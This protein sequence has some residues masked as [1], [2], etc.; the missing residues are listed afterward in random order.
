M[1]KTRRDKANEAILILQSILLTIEF[2]A[3]EEQSALEGIPENMYSRVERCEDTKSD[4]DDA[5]TSLEEA[6][7]Q[8][9]SATER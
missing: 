3:D 7:R 5:K 1:N 4:L 9:E 8:L 2:L 6:I